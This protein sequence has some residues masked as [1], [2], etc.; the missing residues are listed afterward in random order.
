ML[1]RERFLTSPYDARSGMKRNAPKVDGSHS[2]SCDVAMLVFLRPPSRESTSFTCIVKPRTGGCLP[3]PNKR[4][5]IFTRN[6][7][8]EDLLIDRTLIPLIPR[9]CRSDGS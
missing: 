1:S 7:Y 4:K 8:P 2:R 6:A 3:S 9:C 5:G